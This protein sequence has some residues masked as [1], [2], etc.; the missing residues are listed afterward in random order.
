[1]KI[2]ITVDLKDFYADE[3]DNNLSESV[4]N[5]ISSK[6]KNEI[7]DKFKKE[8]F[9]AFSNQVERK[10]NIDKDLKIKE[11]IDDMFKNKQ[12]K[13]R[14]NS[15]TMITIEESIIEELD[16]SINT[17]SN[18]DRKITDLIN[19]KAAEISKDF[20]DRYDLLFASQIVSNLN[21]QGML[22]DDIAKILLENN[23]S[24][25]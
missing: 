24:Q 8:G 25:D 9:E 3:D 16:R 5:A 6:V 17:S 1:M 13:K 18:L 23:A 21:K 22:K 4:K 15:N 10:I 19:K 2:N 7:W 11:I 12:I 14:Y 20:K